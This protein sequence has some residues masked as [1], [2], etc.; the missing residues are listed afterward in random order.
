VPLAKLAMS[1][2][3]CNAGIRFGCSC[4]THSTFVKNAYDYCYLMRGLAATRVFLAATGKTPGLS[5]E[6]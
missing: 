1:M 6:A 4:P 5:L 2:G 3:E